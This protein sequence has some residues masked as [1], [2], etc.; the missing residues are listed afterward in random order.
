MS[1]HDDQLERGADD[2]AFFSQTVRAG[3]ARCGFTMPWYD[4][5]L[6][7]G[8]DSQPPQSADGS[9]SAT[10]PAFD[11]AVARARRRAEALFAEECSAYEAYVRSSAMGQ[12]RFVQQVIK[13][14]TSSDRSAALTLQVQESPFHRLSALAVLMGL[15]R[16]P[17]PKA[18]S[19]ALESLT[20]LFVAS[21]LPAD[22]KLR[23]FVDACRRYVE[24]RNDRLSALGALDTSAVTA[25]AESAGVALTKQQRADVTRDDTLLM[26]WLF[27]D[28]LKIH[29]AA[30]VSA[31]AAS[32]RS[33]LPHFN[34]LAMHRAFDVLHCKPE[35]EDLLLKLICNKL[36][37]PVKAVSSK[38]VFL[39]HKLLVEHPGMLAAVADE[40]ELLVLHPRALPRLRYYAAVCC[41]QVK[42]APG[43]HDLALRLVQMYLRLFAV[44]VKQGIDVQGRALAAIL[45]GINR[46]LPFADCATSAELQE[47]LSSM[48]YVAQSG[49]L[50][51]AVQALSVL[52]QVAQVSSGEFADRFYRVLYQKMLSPELLRSSRQA[53][54]LNVAYRAMAHDTNEARVRAMV[55]RLMQISLVQ[56]S[57]FAAGALMLVAE[58]C[59]LKESVK[60][61]LLKKPRPASDD[62]ELHAT[63]EKN[64]RL[65][66]REQ[67]NA[68][69]DLTVAVA[70]GDESNKN[71]D[72]DND[73]DSSS[74]S[75]ASSSS[76]SSSSEDVVDMDDN[77]LTLPEDLNLSGD[78]DDAGMKP[79]VR[80]EDTQYQPLKLDPRFA[81]AELSG[82]FE[83]SLLT[84][85]VHPSVSVFAQKL[86]AGK[87]LS[88]HGN[89]L[90]DFSTMAFLDRMVYRQPKE[91]KAVDPAGGA[92]LPL[93]IRKR[94]VALPVNSER[95]L[96]LERIQPNDVFFHRFFKREATKRTAPAA[97][98]DDDDDGAGAAGGD[99]EEANDV[100]LDEREFD[101]DD[102]Q[103]DD[104]ADDGGKTDRA[105]FQPWTLSGKEQQ[106]WARSIMEDDFGV[107]GDIG[108]EGEGG[109]ENDVEDEGS[110]LDDFDEA[111]LDNFAA[112]YAA[113]A[114][115]DDDDADE[116]GEFGDD[117]DDDDGGGDALGG[118]QK[119]ARSSST[120][121]DADDFDLL[122]D[123][124]T[125]RGEK[126]AKSWEE[127]SDRSM[128]ADQRRSAQGR[129]RGRSS[130]GG[131]GGGRGRGGRGGRGGG[132]RS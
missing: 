55:K 65:K 113:N 63:L 90:V 97:K 26:L 36:G 100:D 108:D 112:K 104:F 84:R 25:A 51:I 35:G 105:A 81:R 88:Y 115:D 74:S 53:T 2:D 10:S 120:F 9:A 93:R 99:D 102:L 31:L 22:R 83:V 1:R 72:D 110:D 125:T 80:S 127:K 76:S 73:D 58:L 130:G 106:E 109:D 27:E 77:A 119:R 129:G 42:F 123:T 61:M 52:L 47:Q 57:S 107:G 60:L 11:A 101:Y 92:V 70:G 44:M 38:A 87:P 43:D 12:E 28:A 69:A 131:G 20:E 4:V 75:T 18:V 64:W 96:E 62:V 49:S 91:R 79:G 78:A 32:S 21:L 17:N 23:S 67:A 68:N 94:R 15:A 7:L 8:D 66:Q 103:D 37:D 30:F 128:Y 34:K 13:T 24:L 46:A 95:F 56:S 33:A 5:L 41:A 122:L 111:D 89:P 40:I 50:S 114:D 126:K 19:A 82:L 98:D 3:K 14:G 118:K 124:A 86:L 85:H 29:F 117:D 6:S 116:F 39:I 59:K 71:D 121:A 48:L 16:K 54:F 45:V 132:K